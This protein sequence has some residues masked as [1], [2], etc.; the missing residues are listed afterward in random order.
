[1]PLSSAHLISANRAGDS[2]GGG[3]FA[4]LK[5]YLDRKAIR[6]APFSETDLAVNAQF[7]LIDATGFAGTIALGTGSTETNGGYSAAALA[8]AVG[9]AATTSIQDSEGN[10]SNLV[11]VR[12]AS[13]N[14]DILDANGRKVYGLLQAASTVTDGDAV[15]AT[16]SE[17]LQVSFVII[18]TDSTFTLTAVNATVEIALLKLYAERHLSSYRV[19]GGATSRDVVNAPPVAGETVVRGYTITA[20]FAADEVLTITTG[21]GGVSGTST[22]SGDTINSIGATAP[23]FDDDNRARYRVDGVQYQKGTGKDV[24]WDSATTLHFAYPLY[25]GQYVEIE[26]AVAG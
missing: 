23:D 22:P 6:Q 24:I 4:T 21:S 13:T 9:T 16:A 3:N 14:D 18:G 7:T 8:G 1:M 5:D 26:V 19:E 11:Q 10:T 17:N 20:N 2:K 15:G 12:E 25:I